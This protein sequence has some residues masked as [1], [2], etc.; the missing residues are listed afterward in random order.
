MFCLL[1]D[2]LQRG[3]LT[4]SL[5]REDG[6]YYSGKIN[7]ILIVMR[8]EQVFLIQ[9]KISAPQCRNGIPVIQVFM[10]FM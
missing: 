3:H 7:G 6:N 4:L 9:L 5:R 2:I 1:I 8:Q 10:D